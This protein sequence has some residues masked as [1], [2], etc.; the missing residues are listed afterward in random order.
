MKRVGLFVLIVVVI[1]SCNTSGKKNPD[2]LREA[3]GKSGDIVMIIDSVQWNGK[4]GSTLKKLFLPDVPGLPRSEPLFHVMNVHPR[5]DIQL[6]TQ[7]KNLIYV[8]TLDQNTPGTQAMLKR[9]TPET[10]K[11][12]RTD[13][14]F[15]FFGEKDVFAK[16]Q[17]VIY[18]FGDTQEHLIQH[19]KHN[20]QNLVNYFNKLERE[21]LMA[22]T[23]KSKR[24][25][26]IANFLKKE[27]DFE[28][29]IPSGYR[30]ADRGADFVWFR[31]IDPEIDRDIFI[32]WK[33]YNTQYQLSPD[34]LVDWR[35]QIAK[36]YLYE[37]PEN[38]STYL[39]TET[40]VPSNPIIARQVDFNGG[41][42]M[43]VRGLWRTNNKSMGGPFVGYGFVDTSRHRLYYIE[44]FSYSPGK[45]QREIMRGLEAILWTF[46][47]TPMQEAGSK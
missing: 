7:L 44:G 23:M 11:K 28:M 39:V 41:F 9:F 45:S 29:F 4:L 40:N 36:Q 42:A 43:E 47:A 26:D 38:P 6:L 15:Y 14:S 35:D 5:R 33:P 21:R 32:A 17:D 2:Y 27:D 1:I 22:T 3:S 8:F 46:K 12:I 37:D 19:L 18:L 13:T 10:L 31:K 20:G 34:S 24:S 16:G 25:K 30:L